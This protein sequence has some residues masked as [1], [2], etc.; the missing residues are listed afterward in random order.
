M[1]CGWDAELTAER[2]PAQQAARCPS[3]PITS[4]VIL[5]KA[6]PG[7][8]GVFF[9][10]WVGSPTSGLSRLA[11]LQPRGCWCMAMPFRC[12]LGRILLKVL[13][14]PPRI[15]VGKTNSYTQN[16]FDRRKCS[17]K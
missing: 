12:P 9:A 8:F 13:V 11:R 1:G 4:V 5:Q 2:E 17:K 10:V 16:N 14:Q 7:W 6:Q 3:E 15:A